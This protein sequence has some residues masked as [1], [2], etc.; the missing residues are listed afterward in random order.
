ML[1]FVVAYSGQL[2]QQQ[3]QYSACTLLAN[4]IVSVHSYGRLWSQ[5]DK[6]SFSG[7]H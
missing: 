1:E 4:G 7:S 3:Q 5:T 6:S 2:Q